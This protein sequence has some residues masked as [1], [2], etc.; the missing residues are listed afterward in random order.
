[1]AWHHFGDNLHAA[2]KIAGITPERIEKFVGI[3][4]GCRDRQ[5]RLNQLGIWIRRVIRGKSSDP[6]AELDSIIDSHSE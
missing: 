1:M 6:S 3:N 5:E 2:L 4:C